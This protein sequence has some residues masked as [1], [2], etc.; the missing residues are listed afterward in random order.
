MCGRATAWSFSAG[1]AQGAGFDDEAYRRPGATLVEHAAEVYGRADM[2]VKVKEPLPAEYELMRP[3]QLLF[4]YLHLAAVP[5]LGRGA[6]SRRRDRG[7]V[8]DDS[9]SP[10]A[11]CPA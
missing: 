8:R 5:E 11:A 3:G 1:Q 7:R 2:I 6:R 4:T 9:S 10:T